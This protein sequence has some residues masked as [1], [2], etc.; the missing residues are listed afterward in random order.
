MR[1]GAWY[2]NPDRVK[3]ASYFKST[4]GHMHQWNFSLKRVNLH[5]I[6][7]IQD[8]GAE[9]SSAL[10]GC[11]IVDSTRRGKRYPDALSKTVPIWCAVLNQASAERHN[12]PTR[13]IPLCVPSDA[14][15]DSERAQIE[16]RLQQWTAAFLNSDCDIPILMKPLTPIFVNP[17]KIGTL[18]PNAERSHHVVLISASSVNQKAGD[19][20]AQYVQ[21]AGDDHENWALGLSPDLFWNHRSQLIS[22]S[23]DRGQREA[24]I[25]ALVTE[26]STSMQSRANAADDFAS[27]I[28]WIGTT[29]IAVASLQVAYEVCEKNTNP[30]KLMILATHPLSDNTHPQNDTSNCNVIRLNIPQ[31]KRGL[32]AFSQT[33]PEVVDKVTEVLQNS[34]QDCDRRVLLCCAD[35]FNASGAFAVAVLAASFDENRVFL[36]SAEERSQHRSKLCKND[37]HRR[38]QWV[39]SAS[40]LV[41]PS[42]AYLQRVNAGLIGSQ[43]TIRIGS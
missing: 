17:D 5:L 32:N 25:H 37:V 33:L 35:Q 41:S 28:I 23:L 38:L 31:G 18:P 21:G 9:L 16:A 36:A 8:E 15:S 2:T 6:H 19:Y 30:F 22:Q 13:D 11:L 29:R 12:T 7:L 4:D 27:N 1:C 34:V 24:L 3:A 14:V 26:H 40:E 10:T 43:R 20:G 39:I 42:R